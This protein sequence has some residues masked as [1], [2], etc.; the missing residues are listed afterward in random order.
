MSVITLLTDFGHQDAYVAI[1]KGVILSIN[2]QA[3]IV[4][5]THGIDPQ[6]VRQAA[7]LI[8]HTFRFFP[9]GTV[10]IVVVDP[11]VG[12]SRAI[13]ALRKHGHTFLAPNN[14]VLSLILTGNPVDAAY[15]VENA[16]YFLD[17]VSR[18]FHGR[19]ILA[20]VG[21]HL[22][23][24]LPFDQIGPQIDI[25]TLKQ[26][27]LPKT[28]LTSDGAILGAVIDVDR[29]GNLITNLDWDTIKWHYS[30]VE[31]EQFR[32]RIGEHSIVGLSRTYDDVAPE[33]PLAL[34]GS[35]GLLEISVN[36]GNAAALL[37]AAIDTPVIIKVA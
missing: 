23:L 10:H 28:L 20:P 25:S 15:R 33:M 24:G 35:R 13:V 29:Y 8:P 26:L 17:P 18:T 6:N 14:G 16:D 36:R 11:G 31:N 21:A 1:M 34:I 7:F 9:R 19:D 37:G 22:T 32:L 30:K 2:P 5:I 12:S 27:D 4:D 3:T